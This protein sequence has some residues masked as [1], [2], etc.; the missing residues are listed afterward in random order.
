MNGFNCVVPAAK[1]GVIKKRICKHL[2]EGEPTL[3]KHKHK[4]Q[5]YVSFSFFSDKP[6]DLLVAKCIIFNALGS[7]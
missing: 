7:C 5:L 4:N 6:N 2:F 1:F 3:V